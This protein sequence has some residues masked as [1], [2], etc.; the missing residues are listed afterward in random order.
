[1]EKFCSFL[2]SQTPIY[3]KIQPFY[4][5]AFTKGKRKDIHSYRDWHM[6]VHRHFILSWL[7]TENNS[8]VH[9][10]RNG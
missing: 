8:N 6:N 2:K 3:Q 9:E 7:K 1:M 10:Q 4:S 5:Q